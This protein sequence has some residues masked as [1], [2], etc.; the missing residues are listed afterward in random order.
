MLKRLFISIVICMACLVAGAQEQD[1]LPATDMMVELKE[2]VVKGGLPNTRLKGNAMITRVE[3][4][5][6]AQSG[7]LGEMLVK[8]PGMTGS[9][10]AP[11]VLGKGA[12]L[13]YINGRLLRDDSELKRLRSEDIR[14]VEVINNPGAQYDATVRAVVRIRTRRQQGEGLSLD[15]TATDEQDL[16]YDFNRPSSKLGLNYRTGGVD[17]FGSVY[18]FHQDYRQYSWLEETTNTTKLFH[19]EGP[20]TMTWKNDALTYTAGVNWQISDNHSVGIRT[21]LS[22]YLVEPTRSSMT[23]TCL[24]TM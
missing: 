23:R 21:D 22:H 12:P 1:T 15:L 6:L 2:L 20:Y 18:Y 3:G 24:R 5:P 9:E 7:T 13:I 11:E 8:V 17:I 16:R 10:E 4:T 14:D 19:Q